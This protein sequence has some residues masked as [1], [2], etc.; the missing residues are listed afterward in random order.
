MPEKIR[1]YANKSLIGVI[2]K[3]A[4]PKRPGNQDNDDLAAEISAENLADAGWIF[5]TSHAPEATAEKTAIEGPLWTKLK[6]VQNVQAVR[7]NDDAW[8]R[9][10]GP[11]AATQ[12][13]D[14]LRGCIVK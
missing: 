2:P 3:D 10:S 7:V 14:D 6:A 11:T 12:I 1:L 8:V 9:D 5:Y 4:G 13:L